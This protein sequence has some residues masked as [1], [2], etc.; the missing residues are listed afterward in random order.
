MKI[1]DILDKLAEW[2]GLTPR[3]VPVP[4]PKKRDRR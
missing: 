1:G 4:I 2:L 3:P